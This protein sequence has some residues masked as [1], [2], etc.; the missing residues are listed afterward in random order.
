L[1]FS[2][3]E[4]SEIMSEGWNAAGLSV[5]YCAFMIAIMVERCRYT[6]LQ[7]VPQSSPAEIAQTLNSLPGGSNREFHVDAD[8]LHQGVHHFKRFLHSRGFS[9]IEMYSEQDRLKE[10]NDLGA[11]SKKGY[12]LKFPEIIDHEET[13]S[14]SEIADD[15]VVSRDAMFKLYEIKESNYVK[16]SYIF[17][18]M[19]ENTKKIQIENEENYTSPTVVVN[20]FKTGKKVET[21]SEKTKKKNAKRILEMIDDIVGEENVTMY[22]DSVNKL[23][24]KRLKAENENDFD[25]NGINN[26]IELFTNAQMIANDFSVKE[27][28]KTMKKKYNTTTSEEKYQILNL[29]D[30][31]RNA[32]NLILPDGIINDKEIISMTH[33]LLEDTG[34]CNINK[35][36]ILRL[37]NN[38]GI[39]KNFESEVWA[40]LMICSYEEKENEVRNYVLCSLLLN[41]IFLLH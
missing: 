18:E 7:S 23:N 6:K 29:I 35:R 28:M 36:A 27:I 16:A 10:Y 40:N 9:V 21:V 34:L 24:N 41:N 22:L 39:N 17:M 4:I 37:H 30:A 3:G 2:A 31:A 15:V 20:K 13:R 11:H 26:D 38:K 19:H 5:E 25:N 1:K 12:H 8:A 32:C 14:M 33:K